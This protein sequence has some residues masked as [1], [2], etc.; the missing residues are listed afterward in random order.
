[1]PISEYCRSEAHEKMADFI[2]FSF[3]GFKPNEYG[4]DV[5]HSDFKNYVSYFTQSK[6]KLS[7]RSDPKEVY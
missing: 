1:M 3:V 5:R 6:C 4:N 7:G 2:M